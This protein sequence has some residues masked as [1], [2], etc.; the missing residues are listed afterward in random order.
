[1]LNNRK[2]RFPYIIIKIFW[3]NEQNNYLFTKNI[4]KLNYFLLKIVSFFADTN[5]I[6]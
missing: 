1:M 4:T 6:E 3:E 2:T 5:L